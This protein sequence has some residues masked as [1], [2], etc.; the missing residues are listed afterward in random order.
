MSVTRIS[1]ILKM[2]KMRSKDVN[3]LA[4]VMELEGK[5]EGCTFQVCFHNLGLILCSTKTQD[6]KRWVMLMIIQVYGF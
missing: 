6:V 3:S 2:R 5:R 1:P 4:Q